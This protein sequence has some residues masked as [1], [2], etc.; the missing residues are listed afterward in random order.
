MI[1]LQNATKS[2]TNVCIF[3]HLSQCYYF[4]NFFIEKRWGKCLGELNM[5]ENRLEKRVMG[6]Y[7]VNEKVLSEKMEK[8]MTIWK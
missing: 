7:L 1:N 6:K 5:H 3:P 4:T 8:V 2:L